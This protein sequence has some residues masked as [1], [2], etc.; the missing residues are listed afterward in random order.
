MSAQMELWPDDAPSSALSWS[1][2]RHLRLR[3]CARKYYLFH[4][5]S[6]GGQA[7]DA[8]KEKRQTFVLRQLRTRY[9][10]VG[11][12]VHEMIELALSAR[13]RGE[14]VQVDAVV[15]RGTRRMRAQY[16]ESVQKVYRDRPQTGFGLVEHEYQETVT[17]EE[18]QSMRERMERS[19]RT[20]FALPLVE[21]IASM[22]PWRWL[23]LEALGNFDLDGATVVVRPDFAWRE[24]DGTISIVDWKTGRSRVDDERLQLAIYGL[25]A[26]RSWGLRDVPMKAIVVHLDP[27]EGEGAVDT[28]ELTPADLDAAEVV[29]RQSL[30]E[31]RAIAESPTTEP[32]V[33][34][35]PMTDDLARCSRCSFRRICARG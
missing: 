33:A 5:Q 14:D 25:Y 12:V 28:H 21:Q 6:R 15:E 32:D 35:F 13:R 1:L 22:P 17:R 20:F 30:N 7:P 23:S 8:P 3:D 11:E 9:M 4:F 27:Q 26:R 34:R 24:P 18:W 16:A 29:V 10:W 31:M 19:L 2:S